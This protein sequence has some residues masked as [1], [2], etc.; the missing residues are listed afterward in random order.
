MTD[1]ARLPERRPVATLAFAVLVCEAVGISGSVFTALGLGSWYGS[2][3][4]PALAPPNWVFGPVW[5]TLFALLGLAAWLVWRRLDRLDAPAARLAMATFVAQFVLNL[6]WSAVFFGARSL[7]GGLL[8][9]VALWLA[10]LATVVAFGRVD[11]RAGA[12]LLPYLAWV[13]FAGYLNYAFW[14]LN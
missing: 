3:A 8:V 9:I 5:T 11:R 7:A 10:I 13:S 12:L 6:A 14:A 2:L 1:L 4:R